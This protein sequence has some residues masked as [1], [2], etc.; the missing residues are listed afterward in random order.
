ME[1]RVGNVIPTKEQVSEFTTKLRDVLAFIK[2]FGV[3]LSDDERTSRSHPRKNSDT[4]VETVLKLAGEY[5][6]S[7]PNAPIQGVR[8]D[9]DLVSRIEPMLPQLPLLQQTLKDTIAQAEHEYWEGFLAYYGALVSMSSR[10][11]ELAIALK[12]VIDFMSI[13]KRK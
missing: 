3:V 10:I 12:E 1:N 11:P 6:L 8:D 2:T 4:H 13:G 9:F 5:G 7:L